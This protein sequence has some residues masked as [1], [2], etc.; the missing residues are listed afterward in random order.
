VLLDPVKRP[1]VA[2]QLAELLRRLSLSGGGALV[3]ADLQAKLATPVAHVFEER[4]AARPAFGVFSSSSALFVFV[5]GCSFQ[6]H[7]NETYR[8][9]VGSTDRRNDGPI[10][11]YFRDLAAQV[12]TRVESFPGLPTLQIRLVG[13]SLGGAVCEEIARLLRPTAGQSFVQVCTFGA[14]KPFGY[15]DCQYVSAY[16]H[17]RYMNSDD[18]V[19]LVFP[20]ANDNPALLIMPGPV[21]MLRAQGFTQPA[22]G[23]ELLPSGTIRAA[24]LPSTAAI[25]AVSNIGAWLYLIDNG[26]ATAHDLDAYIQR[27]DAWLARGYTP[28]EQ[29][30]PSMVIE[31]NEDNSRV[32]LTQQE[33]A[34]VG[35]FRAR[36]R[37]QRSREPVVPPARRVT[38]EKIGKFYRTMWGTSMVSTSL[39]ARSSRKVK[40]TLN[41]LIQELLKQGLVDP[42]SLTGE[43]AAFVQAASNPGNGVSPLLAVTPPGE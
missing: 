18:P 39:S 37:E 2:V 22:G 11:P 33:K 3:Q 13:H 23:L 12:M 6:G 9:Y 16:P 17:A 4:T 15:G 8:G 38:V 1:D 14:P 26:Q 35:R 30:R 41:E 10:N 24:T 27:M 42:H 31:D 25:D 36:E 20:S 19:P 21:A 29:P 34:V 43:L 40:N 7:G 28:S 5:E 32:N